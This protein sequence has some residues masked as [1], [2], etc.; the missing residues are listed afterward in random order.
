MFCHKQRR[1]WPGGSRGRTPLPL[2]CPVG[3]MWNAKIRWEFFVEGVGW[4]RQP[5]MT[6]LPRPLLNLQT[7]LRRWGRPRLNPP[8]HDDEWNRNFDW[9]WLNA[10]LNM[11]IKN[12]FIPKNRGGTLHY[13][14]T[15]LKN[16]KLSYCWETVRRESMLRIAEMDVEMTT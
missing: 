6:N 5:L 8:L 1:S 11:C 9:F 4:G 16:K 10:M 13:V 12:I 3:S 15:A 2:S 7:R 14:P